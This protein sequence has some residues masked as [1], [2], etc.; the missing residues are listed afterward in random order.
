MTNPF[1]PHDLPGKIDAIAAS[2]VALSSRRSSAS[3]VIWQDGVV[4]TSA[5][6]LWRTSSP[7][8]IL[9]DGERVAGEVVGGDAA[10]DLAIV[11]VAAAGSPALARETQTSSR[12]GDFAFAV[13]RGASGLVQASFGFVG[14]VAG[15][16]KT[17]R[18]ARVERLIRLD[19]G[20][21]PGFDGA[22][23]A[24]AQ[25]RFVGIAS[26]AL[27]RHHAVVLPLETVD[28]IVAQ[29]L[30]HGHVP[31]GYLGIAAQPVSVEW[32]GKGVD[33]LLVSSVADEGPAAR[34][35]LKVADVILEVGSTPVATLDR[36]RDVL[37]VDQPAVVRALRGDRL[38]E[39][40]IT[41]AQRPAGR[42][43]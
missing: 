25:G 15:E 16:W 10:T 14:S 8:V 13:A 9:P 41:A 21:Y 7:S 19:G 43:R 23:V 42:C 34:G 2:V 36:L 40:T 38:V 20:L 22:P 29:I 35:G 31:R 28:R 5:S 17:W 33:G 18:G 37:Q 3:G 30:A 39:L 12:V 4:V 27:S 6:S 1:V 26:S 24:D 11:R 32:E